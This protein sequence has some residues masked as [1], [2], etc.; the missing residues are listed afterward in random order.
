VRE[1]RDV[2]EREEIDGCCHAQDGGRGRVQGCPRVA[3]A[4]CFR[5]PEV[6]YYV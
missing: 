2:G 3:G 6:K 1:E 5:T 4:R